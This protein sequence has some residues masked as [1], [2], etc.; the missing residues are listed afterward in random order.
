MLTLDLERFMIELD[1]GAIKH[2]GPSNQSGT[3]K[4]YDVD[5]IEVRE[6][7]DRQIK[8][9]FEDADGNKVEVALFAEQAATVARGIE[10]LESESEVFE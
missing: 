10:E 7:G 6:F 9:A 8:L 1:E 2:V 5:G 4:L 3:V